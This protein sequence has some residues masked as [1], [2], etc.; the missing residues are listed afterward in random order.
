MRTTA[1]SRY[2]RW[3]AGTAAAGGALLLG[4]ALAFLALAIHH[5]TLAGGSGATH[6]FVSPGVEA[7][8]GLASLAA[9]FAGAWVWWHARRDDDAVASRLS[10]GAWV[11]TMAAWAVLGA[12]FLVLNH[13]GYAG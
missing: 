7:A 2:L 13:D 10:I 9:I 8:F 1:G 5:A 3:A 11:A 4:S 12:A 6:V